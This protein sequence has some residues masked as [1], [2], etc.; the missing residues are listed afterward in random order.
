MIDGAIPTLPGKNRLPGRRQAL[1]YLREII[2]LFDDLL[3]R[4]D[5]HFSSENTLMKQTRF[6]AI[7]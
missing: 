5:V 7:R 3:R 1:P 2:N 4:T 6:P